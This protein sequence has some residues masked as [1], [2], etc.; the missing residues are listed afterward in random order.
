MMA[1]GL[2]QCG[3]LANPVAAL[4]TIAAIVIACLSLSGPALAAGS[5]R[6]LVRDAG[7]ADTEVG[8]IVYDLDT[9][10]V[11]RSHLADQ[12]FI[13]ASMVKL[14]TALAALEV[15]GPDHRF[16]TRVLAVP[17]AGGV[18][19]HLSG[20][21]DPVLVQENLDRLAESLVVPLAGRPVVRF[22]FDDGTLPFV[23]QI[24]P[25]DDGLKPY[26]PPIS[27][28][29]VNFNRQWLR[30]TRDP[31]SRA[32][33]VSLRPD[34]GD[35]LAGIAPRPLPDGRS[36]E[37][38]GSARLRYLLTPQVP[39]E[40]QRRVAVRAPARHAAAMLRAYAARAGV[41]LPPPEAAK[42]PPAGATEIAVHESRPLLLAVRDLLDYSNNLSAELIGLATA[43]A[44]NPKTRTL[45]EG[46]A[47]VR[48]W[49]DRTV[50]AVTRAGWQTVNQSGLS[51]RT[52]ATPRALL[53]LLR[54]ASGRSYA[55]PPEWQAQEG[56]GKASQA[57]EP[58]PFLALLRPPSWVED[59]DTDLGGK[60]GTMY[61]ARG[62]AG[63]L[64][65]ASGRR[66][67]FVL[68]HTDLAAR[69]AYE[70]NPARFRAPVQIRARAWLARAKR[71]E[72]QILEYWVASL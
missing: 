45:A 2:G 38:V 54:F 53:E 44:L 26:N 71:L 11:L 33:L 6:A 5:E 28:L 59:R 23:P 47:A 72:Q 63:V 62:Q 30:W 27:A 24:D 52:R 4:V 9:S 60:S 50:P 57:G 29:S 12:A 22:T 3:A 21:G 34:L 55:P 35:A 51:G 69:G 67:L 14:A 61:Y 65:A 46:A 1:K 56:E 43:R 16:R 20:G 48:A 15:L 40:G 7:F 18:H 19:L 70:A 41:A 31:T 13:P 64:T 36:V 68:M 32:L 66:V 10:R 8:Y 17:V 49:L 39:S 58:V 25:G 37:A 42:G